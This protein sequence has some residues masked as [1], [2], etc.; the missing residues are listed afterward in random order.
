MM[1]VAHDREER[2]EDEQVRLKRER[3]EFRKQQEL[4]S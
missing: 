4:V 3:R 1:E 2:R